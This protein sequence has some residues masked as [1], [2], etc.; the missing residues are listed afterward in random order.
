MKARRIT[1]KLIA[2][3]DELTALLALL[4]T[5]RNRLVESGDSETPLGKALWAA[6]DGVGS[7]LEAHSRKRAGLV[8]LAQSKLNKLK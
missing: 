6:T 8:T 7:V 5:E 3:P 4:E 1:A 2:T